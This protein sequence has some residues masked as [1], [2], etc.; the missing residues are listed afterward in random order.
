MN[1]INNRR[2][3]I[4][5]GLAVINPPIAKVGNPRNFEESGAGVAP[6]PGVQGGQMSA[7]PHQMGGG[8]GGYGQQQQAYAAPRPSAPASAGGGMATGPHNGN[9]GYGVPKGQ[10]PYAPR[11]ASRPAPSGPVESY[12]S[13][14]PRFVAIRDVN[15]YLNKWTIKARVTSK[16]DIRRWSNVK[17]EGYLMNIELLDSQGGEIRATFFKEAVDMFD[18]ILQLGS[19]YSFSNGKVKAANAQYNNTNSDYEITFNTDS[20]ITPLTDDSGIKSLN[21]Q[22]TPIEKL[23][24]MEPNSMVDVL[25]VVKEVHDCTNVTTRNDK[26]TTRRNLTLADSS[27]VQI[28]VTLW[29]GHAAHPDQYFANNPVL[30]IKGA[31]LSDYNGRSLSTF[32]SSSMFVNPDI[33][34]TAMLQ[35]WWRKGGAGLGLKSVSVE[36]GGGVGGGQKGMDDVGGR[37]AISE[38]MERSLGL[39][40]KPDYVDIKG[41]VSFVKHD[42]D[43]GPWYTSCPAEGCNKKVTQSVDNGWHCEK[44]NRT[45]PN[46]MR[47]YILSI[48]LVDHT[49]RAYFTAFNDTA[50]PLLG[51]I[52]AETLNEWKENGQEA[53]YED[54]FLEV[55]HKQVLCRVRVKAEMVNDEQRIKNTI[56]SA[57]FVNPE[58]ESANLLKAINEYMGKQ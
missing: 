14:Q 28:N 2:L 30:A 6:H 44:C 58:K 53:Q 8:G 29:G 5:L 38:I 42:Q 46:C 27:G 32:N 3:L 26:E 52:S 49:G 56:Y 13:G 35:D 22:A 15:P 23:E 55:L 19:V 33:P 18:P 1:V 16:G 7:Q 12:Q 39:G 21:L 51:D 24:S 43:R 31:K 47:R 20:V 10:S 50:Q 36:G 34:G 25:G 11:S 57:S 54:A 48:S 9:M 40:S 41:L 37:L 4:V 17:G 45:Y